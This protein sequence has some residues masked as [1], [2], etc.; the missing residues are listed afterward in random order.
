MKSFTR[1][2][3]LDTQYGISAAAIKTTSIADKNL[4]KWHS[5]IS[6]L[7]DSLQ[8]LMAAGSQLKHTVTLNK[9]EQKG[10]SCD[11][12]TDLR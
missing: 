5:P 10:I 11:E 1:F 7:T 12:G 2:P 8:E 3:E 6:V 4:P 9:K